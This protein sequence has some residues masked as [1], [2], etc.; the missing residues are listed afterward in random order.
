[1][2][3]HIQNILYFSSIQDHD[4]VS[5]PTQHYIA[6]SYHKRKHLVELGVEVWFFTK[7]ETDEVPCL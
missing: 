3:I 4:C 1:M 6:Y 2:A 5:R 7:N